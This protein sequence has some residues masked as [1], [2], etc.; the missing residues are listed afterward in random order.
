VLSLW[1]AYQ[2]RVVRDE[3]GVSVTEYALLAA[4]MAVVALAAALVLGGALDTRFK[5][6]GP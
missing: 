2:S 1:T 6:A 4:L 5:G 3:R